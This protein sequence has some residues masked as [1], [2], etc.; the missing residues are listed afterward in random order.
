[1]RA[2]CV[3]MEQFESRPLL[4]AGVVDPTF[5]PAYQNWRMP[6]VGAEV[7]AQL[8]GK[9]LHYA[10]IGPNT[11]SSQIWRTNLNGSLDTSFGSNG[12][13]NLGSAPITKYAATAD[14]K[15]VVLMQNFGTTLELRRYN[16]NGSAEA[17]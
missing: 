10:H 15:I 7:H 12:V 13:I 2:I 3:C 4:S 14:G 17:S 11:D 6:T 1:M 8:D 5:S 9:M 16:A